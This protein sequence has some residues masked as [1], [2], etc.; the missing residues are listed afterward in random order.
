MSSVG[1]LLF[2]MLFHE[3]REVTDMLFLVLLHL[4]PERLAVGV[5][6]GVFHVLVLD[7]PERFVFLGELLYEVVGV[8]IQHNTNIQMN[9]NLLMSC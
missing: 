8:V 6:F 9:A 7:A 3:F 4:F 5:S 2:Q 1:L